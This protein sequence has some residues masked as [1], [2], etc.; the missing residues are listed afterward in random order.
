MSISSYHEN[1]PKKSYTACF[2]GTIYNS[3]YSAFPTSE[4]NQCSHGSCLK[5]TSDHTHL[6]NHS[7]LPF[8][9]P[10]PV[11]AGKFSGT[12]TSAIRRSNAKRFPDFPR[13]LIVL[14]PEKDFPF[15]YNPDLFSGVHPGG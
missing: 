2:G 1:S 11:V 14:D 3:F 12:R 4:E 5:L 15:F 10:E 7:N 6:F 9:M 13:P 8:R